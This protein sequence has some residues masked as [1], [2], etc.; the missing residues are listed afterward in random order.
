VTHKH[1]GSSNLLIDRCI[2]IVSRAD[3]FEGIMS[4]AANATTTIDSK[5]PTTKQ[6]I[7]AANTKLLI[8]QLE[9]GHSEALTNYLTCMSRFHNYSF[10][11][12]MK[13]AP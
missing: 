13:I 12:V 8:K 2:H 3:G 11:N 5:K 4:S 1:A 9:P 6:E 10:G 7:I